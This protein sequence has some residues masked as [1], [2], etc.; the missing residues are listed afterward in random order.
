MPPS[1]TT[2]FIL[3]IGLF[4]VSAF[5]LASIAIVSTWESCRGS[6]GKNIFS[7]LDCERVLSLHVPQVLTAFLY[8]AHIGQ[9]TYGK[10]WALQEV[11]KYIGSDCGCINCLDWIWGKLSS[12]KCGLSC[13]LEGDDMYLYLMKD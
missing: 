10:T 4:V 1:W 11:H 5:F 7:F 2:N 12:T 13:R 3:L 9:E 8:I 6:F